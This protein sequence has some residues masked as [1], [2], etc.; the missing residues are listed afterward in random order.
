[1]LS[2]ANVAR[3][4]NFD[5]YA[6]CRNS[7]ESKKFR[8]DN[9]F[10]IGSW[11]DR[12]VSERLSYILGLNGY[13]NLINT[14]LFINK[15]NKIKPDLIHIHSLC[16]NY[17]NINMLFNYI[18]KNN[19]PVV[20]TL[21][22]SW[23]FTGRCA[24]NRCLKWQEGCGNCPHK[25]YYPGTLFLDNSRM[26]FSKRKKLYSKIKN[27]TIV[28]PSKWLA[29]YAIIHFGNTHIIK[30]INNGIDLN[31]FK[32]QKSSFKED[33]GINDKYIILGLA[34]YWDD[35]KGLNDFIKLSKDLPNSIRI[36]LVGTNDEVDKLLPK[37]IISIHRTQSQKELVKIYSAA[38]LFVNPT[39][40]ENFP[41][42]NIEAQ[43]CGLP[44]LTYSTGGSGEMISEKTGSIVKTGDYANLLSEILRISKGKPYSKE[45]C[46]T[47]AKKY[48]KDDRFIDYIVLY[49]KILNC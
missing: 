24:Q 5:V 29:D 44:V 10:Y 6:F 7:R 13:F 11:L 30:V 39:Y 43:A 3:N 35:S 25:D 18:Y 22:D 4:S 48:N 8:Y 16:D 15:L 32:Y 21:H 1:M 31:V 40:D 26:V 9:L 46:I 47:Q 42:V 19:I 45:D 2:I 28:T 17:L 41:T 27:M 14:R 49:K 12:I 37:N 23:A 34:Y 36:V 38:D 33:Y 20:W